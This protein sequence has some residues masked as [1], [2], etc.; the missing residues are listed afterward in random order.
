MVSQRGGL[1]R[2]TRTELN[3]LRILWQQ[4]P[5]TVRE[6]H[7]ALNEAGPSGYTTA[8]KMLQVMHHKGLVQR[9]AS[10][11]AHVY[12]AALNKQETQRSFLSD[13]VHRLFDG[14]TSQLVLQALGNAPRAD[15]ARLQR[16]E[17]LLGEMEI[18]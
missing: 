6:V 5:S 7:E 14:S 18:R 1:P 9:D 13:L 11:R 17:R 12:A 16:L 10:R 15:Q 3:I 4:G 8:L 2:P